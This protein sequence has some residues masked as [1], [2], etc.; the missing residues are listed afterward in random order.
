[1]IKIPY[2][3]DYQYFHNDEN[4]AVLKPEHFQD[5]SGDESNIVKETLKN[6]ISSDRLSELA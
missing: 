1:M 6:P 4:V 3:K 5:N 2:G